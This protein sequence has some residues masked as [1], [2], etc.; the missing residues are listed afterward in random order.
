MT[1]FTVPAYGKINLTLDVLRKRPDGY[2]DVEMVMQSIEL[3]DLIIL[4]D[5]EVEGIKIRCEHPYVPENE[6]NLAYKAAHLLMQECDIKR[7]IEIEIKKNI[8]VAAGLAGGSSNAA[9][10]LTGLNQMWQLG[11]SQQDLMRIG[12]RLGADVPFCIMGGTALATGIGTDLTPLP[13]APEMELVL[14]TPG[15]GVSTKEIY[16][17]YTPDLVELRPDL[18]AMRQALLAENREKIKKYLVN[19]LEP[20]TLHFY[21][22]VA[23][24]K[25]LMEDTGFDPVVMSGSGPTLFT[26]VDTPAQGDE[27][28]AKLQSKVSERVIRTK[29]RS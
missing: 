16:T 29:T 8:P 17:R 5:D 26:V 10:V 18:A 25:K 13:A 6:S 2:H 22:R 28:A 14:Y 23:G 3:H 15:I 24:A 27:L 19:V 20:I 7:N 11:L 4:R 1:V 9:G 21:P 12:A